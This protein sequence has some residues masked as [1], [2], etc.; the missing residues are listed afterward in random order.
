[1]NADVTETIDPS[2]YYSIRQMWKMKVF[3]WIHSYPAY[4]RF[5]Q[6]DAQKETRLLETIITG[7]SSATRYLIKGSAIIKVQELAKTGYTFEF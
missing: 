3:D 5:V 6:R 1:M 4:K 2:K 7:N